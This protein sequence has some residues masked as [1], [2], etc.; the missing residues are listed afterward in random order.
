MLAGDWKGVLWD[1]WASAEKLVCTIWKNVSVH[2]PI[3][4][5]L[6]DESSKEAIVNIQ[7]QSLSDARYMVD[8]SKSTARP[9]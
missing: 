7:L 3:Y 4:L 1:K 5:W 9:C 6:I 2:V 8:W